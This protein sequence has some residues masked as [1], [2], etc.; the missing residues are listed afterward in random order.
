[1]TALR[2]IPIHCPAAKPRMFL[3]THP[4]EWF[5]RFKQ[6]AF[7]RLYQYLAGFTFDDWTMMNYGFEPDDS[8][9]LTLKAQDEPD[10]YCIQLYERVTAGVDLRGNSLLEVGCG[11]GGGLSYLHRYRGPGPTR[12]CDLSPR[13]VAF[14]A[15]R[16]RDGF[17][18]QFRV[19]DALA[20]PYD[21][22]MFDCVVNVESSHCYPSR[23]KFFAEV[24][25]VLKPGGTFCYADLHEAGVNLEIGQRLHEAGFFRVEREDLTPGVLRAL[26]LDDDRKRQLIATRAPLGLRTLVG[27]F[28]GLVGTRT[29]RS[30]VVGA[31]Q[32]TR[33]KLRK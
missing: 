28:A 3:W 29:H 5:P 11:R 32:Y 1:M 8:E 13:A 21:D 30:F 33:W 18:L 2:T 15:N 9:R 19:G 6:W 25:R 22:A 23:A 14:C 24:Y 20:L 31:R 4:L 7:K 26:E 27:M 16:H 12:G 17:N 10:R